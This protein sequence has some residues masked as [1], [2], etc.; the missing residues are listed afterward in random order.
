RARHCATIHRQSVLKYVLQRPA[1]SAV[2][3][4]HWRTCDS[5]PGWLLI[6]NAQSYA[7]DCRRQEVK[8]QHLLFWSQVPQ[9]YR[10]ALSST[11]CWR[12]ALLC[13]LSSVIL[14]RT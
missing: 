13:V 4:G 8:C 6:R 1:D 7:T 10:V 2:G 9:A 11:R 3:N 12:M 5:D 14:L